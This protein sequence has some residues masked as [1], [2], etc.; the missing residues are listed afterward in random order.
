MTFSLQL[1]PFHPAF[2]SPARLDLEV[3]GATIAGADLS[4]G[5]G[6]RGVE[7][8]AQDMT[9]AQNLP[10][11]E[12]ICAC[13]G[14]S[15]ALAYTQAVESISK[16]AVP[17]R[18]LSI[19]TVFGEL[20]RLQTHLSLLERCLSLVALDPL[21]GRFMQLREHVADVCE[22]LSG[23]RVMFDILAFGGCR[24]DLAS[25]QELSAA[26]S[27]MKD[28][29]RKAVDLFIHDSSI[30]GRMVGIGVLTL[31]TAKD[32][33]LVG[34]AARA[35]GLNMDIRRQAPYAAYDGLDV[36]VVSQTGGDVF[37]RLAVR[38][39]E[40]LESIRLIEQVTSEMPETPFVTGRDVMAPSGIGISRVESPSGE[41]FV[42]VNAASGQRPDRIHVRPASF[43]NLSVVS[44]VLVGQDL[45]DAVLILLSFGACFACADR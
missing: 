12:R 21:A 44:K 23:N 45:E 28:S 29:T 15:T 5:Y 13:S 22:S 30:A 19:R 1:G 42:L 7:A 43:V 31:E 39:L 11:L 14:Y 10:L 26:I 35:S 38:A 17:A 24:K 6:H 36:N 25:A 9:F 34:P 33:G 3:E 16:L 18:A 40:C 2:S 37:S 8:L 4:L 41:V 20:E 27:I 32:Y